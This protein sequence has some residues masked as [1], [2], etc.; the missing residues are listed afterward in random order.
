M[1]IPFYG[2]SYNLTTK[3]T[4][5]YAPASG[6]GIAGPYTQQNGYLGY[7]EVNIVIL[8]LI[9]NFKYTMEV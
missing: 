6:A 2:V 7:N 9:Q 8:F 5:L 1:G 3:N 4:S